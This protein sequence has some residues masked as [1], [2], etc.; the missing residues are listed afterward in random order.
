MNVY[1]RESKE[2]L[3]AVVQKG[4][5][6][7]TVGVYFAVVG[8]NSRPQDEDWIPALVM[9]GRT[10][11]LVENYPVGTYMVWTRIIDDPEDVVKKLGMFRVV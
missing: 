1:E 9:D 4:N 10:G 11:L 6:V 8:I 7:L 3:R 5:E 2:F